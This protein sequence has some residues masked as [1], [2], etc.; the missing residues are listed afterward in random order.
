MKVYEEAGRE[1][2]V[3]HRATARYA[4]LNTAAS[5]RAASSGQ[6]T[7]SCLVKGDY[8]NITNVPRCSMVVSEYHKEA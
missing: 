2:K 7:K 3:E 6:G 8:D 1:R 5:L 4:C